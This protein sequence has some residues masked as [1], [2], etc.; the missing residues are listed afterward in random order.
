MK[1]KDLL[2]STLVIIS[3]AIFLSVGILGIFSKE[4]SKW[5]LDKHE[6]REKTRYYNNLKFSCDIELSKKTDGFGNCNSLIEFLEKEKKEEESKK[7]LSSLCE[8][9]DPTS[10]FKIYQNNPSIIKSRKKELL[11]TACK[12]GFGGSLEACGELGIILKGEGNLALANKY[13][14]Y[15]CNIGLKKYCSL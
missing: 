15:A 14:K 1:I 9:K 10:C 4:I 3:L 5:V 13:F 12:E 2:P 11:I 6:S 8:L 7:L